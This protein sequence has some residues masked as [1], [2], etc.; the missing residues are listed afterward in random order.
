MPFNTPQDISPNFHLAISDLFSYPI[1]SHKAGKYGIG[2]AEKLCPPGEAAGRQMGYMR[3][4][5]YIKYLCL[6]I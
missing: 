6:G 1:Y 4:Q 5:D 3:E 2:P